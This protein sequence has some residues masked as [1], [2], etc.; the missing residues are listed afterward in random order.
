MMRK[1]E[2]ENKYY[3]DNQI[4]GAYE[5][6]DLNWT[7]DQSGEKSG[8]IFEDTQISSQDGNIM[9]ERIM[10]VDGKAFTVCSIFPQA[11]S[12][13]PTQKMLEIIEQDLKK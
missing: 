9:A 5:T 11:P 10:W 6:R 4:F 3:L 12:S 13:T 7:V 8:Q 2:N 1:T